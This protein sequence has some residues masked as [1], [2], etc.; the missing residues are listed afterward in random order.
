ML[1]IKTS[2]KPFLSIIVPCLDCEKSLGHLFDNLRELKNASC[3][4]IFVDNGSTDGTSTLL[5]KF[6]S[7]PK[8]ENV[9]H[10]YF[11]K[12]SGPGAARQHGIEAALGEYIFFVDSDDQIDACGLATVLEE[13][14]QNSKFDDIV[15]C[16]AS[17]HD[18]AG[19]ISSR[20]ELQYFS[21]KKNRYPE[22]FFVE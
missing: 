5:K 4:V 8:K 2:S 1:E 7:G 22:R 13:L 12:Q 10:L 20:D 6:S 18:R 21:G 9:R 15:F 16:N 17:I 14:Q 3:E 11:D 19:K